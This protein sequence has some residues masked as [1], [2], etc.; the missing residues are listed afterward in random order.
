ME[1]ATVLAFCTG[2]MGGI[3]L[4][5]ALFIAVVEFIKR[6]WEKLN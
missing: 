3:L 4:G 1:T 6:R 2:V 5:A